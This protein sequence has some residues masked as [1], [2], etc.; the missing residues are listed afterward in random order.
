M[1]DLPVE[2]RE[3]IA[4]IEKEVGVPVG[5][6]SYGPKRSQTIIRE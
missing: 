2:A 6:V 3:Y 5:I 4:F 1:K